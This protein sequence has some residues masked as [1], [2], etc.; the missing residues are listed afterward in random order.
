MTGFFNRTYF[1]DVMRRMHGILQQLKPLSIIAID[2]DSLK[3]TNDTFG[4][5]AGDSLI[6]EAAE[7]ALYFR[8]PIT[9]LHKKKQNR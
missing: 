7:T 5:N 3:I 9:P 4:H 6:K 8:T 2:I 1:E